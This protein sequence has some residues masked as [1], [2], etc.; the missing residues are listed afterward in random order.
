MPPKE[1]VRRSNPL[2]VAVLTREEGQPAKVGGYG[3]VFFREGEAGTEYQLWEDFFE[4]IMPGAFD[5]A[6]NADVRSLFNHDPNIVL[7]RTS[8]GTLKLSVDAKGLLYETTLPDTQ[9]VRDQVLSPITRKEVTGSSFMF[10]PTDV[11]YREKEGVYYREINKVELLE[12]GPVTFPAYEGSTTGV[13]SVKPEDTAEARASFDAWKAGQLGA[14]AQRDRDQAD[15]AA[16]MISVQ[17]GY[18]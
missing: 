3:A 4:R 12:V 14:Q 8:A 2:P 11:T 1:I 10:Y 13:R 16:A 5:D 17:M 7:G 6:I 15:A 18:L 9:L